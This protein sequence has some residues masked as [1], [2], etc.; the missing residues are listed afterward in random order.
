MALYQF[1]W[2]LVSGALHDSR[3]ALFPALKAIG[4]QDEEV[5]W[6]WAAM[7]YGA[8]QTEDLFE[9]WQAHVVGQGEWRASQYA[10]YSVKAVDLTAYW[11]PTLKGLKSKHYD[12]EADKALPVLRGD[13]SAAVARLAKSRVPQ[14]AVPRPVC[15]CR[16]A[17]R[18]QVVCQHP[19]QH[20]ALSRHQAVGADAV[21][22][23][24]P[25]PAVIGCRSKT[26]SL[27]TS[28]RKKLL[29]R[30]L[31]FYPKQPGQTPKEGTQSIQPSFPLSGAL[32]IISIKIKK[33][34]SRPATGILYQHIDR[35]H[36]MF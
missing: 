33:T 31:K 13:D 20:I 5:R 32:N 35:L 29:F 14:R 6:A 2:M 18:A 36:E 26:A 21:P 30:M 1:L 34:S 23:G 8:W 16:D 17:G 28:T 4:L 19:P 10:G 25:R 27:L 12:A 9:S 11:R 22:A 3:G 15:A 7:R 24:L